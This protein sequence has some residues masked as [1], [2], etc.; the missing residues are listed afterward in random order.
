MGR[1]SLQH[2]LLYAKAWYATYNS[3][4]TKNTTIWE[5]MVA[6]LEADGWEGTFEGDSLAQVK[7]R[8]AYI[9][10]GKLGE[11]SNKE[12]KEMMQNLYEGIH[13]NNCWKFG[14]Y[15][16]NYT[17]LR[18]QEEIDKDPEYDFDE[19]VV[20]YCLSNFFLVE[21]DE[22]NPIRPNINV[23]PYKDGITEEKIDKHFNKHI[24]N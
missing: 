1:T 18:R 9:L 4:D 22:W 8:V 19:A 16:K 5:D 20:R 17:F 10:I 12:P 6:V 14:Y 21:T 11:L 23:L 24:I 2:T 7:N 13:P 15:T 3:K